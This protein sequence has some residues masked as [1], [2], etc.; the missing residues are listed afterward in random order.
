MS[1][2]TEN[3]RKKKL[4]KTKMIKLN[5]SSNEKWNQIYMKSFQN[6]CLQRQKLRKIYCKRKQKIKD[7]PQ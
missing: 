6:I 4:K 5:T 2:K 3:K 1:L 7:L